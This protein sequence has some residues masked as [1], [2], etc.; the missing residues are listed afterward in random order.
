MIK[1]LI[2]I[3]G[4]LCWHKRTFKN[5]TFKDQQLKLSGEIGEWNA[6]ID[7]FI[8]TAQIRHKFHAEEELADVV[9]AATNLYNYPEM[10]RLIK[11]KMKFPQ[12]K[13]F[14]KL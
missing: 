2:Q 4:I 13:Q 11:K 3:F 8:R 14:R 9:I 7:D 10:R 5:F 12:K 6:A 1:A